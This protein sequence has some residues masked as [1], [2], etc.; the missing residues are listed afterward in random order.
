[1]CNGKVAV[2]DELTIWNIPP[3]HTPFTGSRVVCKPSPDL[4]SRLA[5]ELVICRLIVV[6]VPLAVLTEEM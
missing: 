4:I 2:T 6:T 3:D 5:P 1:M